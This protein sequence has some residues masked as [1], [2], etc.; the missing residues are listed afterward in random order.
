MPSR[1]KNVSSKADDNDDR[2]S[3]TIMFVR[4][5]LRGGGT[6]DMTSDTEE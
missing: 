5:L 3:D 1:Q 2:S 6:R 4:A